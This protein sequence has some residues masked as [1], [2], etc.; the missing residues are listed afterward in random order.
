VR[1][2]LAREALIPILKPQ[3]YIYLIGWDKPSKLDRLASMDGRRAHERRASRLRAHG[4]RAQG[5]GPVRA[6]L[7]AMHSAAKSIED[8]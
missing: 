5:G 2:P 7:K 3:V 4:R 6:N 8:T 1:L